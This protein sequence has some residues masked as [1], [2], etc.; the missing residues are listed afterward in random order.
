VKNDDDD[1]WGEFDQGSKPKGSY[2]GGDNNT[3]TSGRGRVNAS[4]FPTFA[5][6]TQNKKEE[7]D[8]WGLDNSG[9]SKTKFTGSNFG[10]NKK[11]DDDDDD[12]EDL[13]GGI[14][15]KRGISSASKEKEQPQ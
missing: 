12:L 5:G 7:E 13:L 8:E 11:K 2:R 14:E 6:S 15:A 3:A 9:P 1:E 10:G 4:N